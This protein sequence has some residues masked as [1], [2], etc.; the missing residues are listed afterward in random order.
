MVTI[1]RTKFARTINS[2]GAHQIPNRINLFDVWLSAGGQT[3][4]DIVK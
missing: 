2:G 4:D 1:G 3:F